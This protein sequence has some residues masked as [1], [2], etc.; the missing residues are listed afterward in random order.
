MAMRKRETIA[1]LMPKSR[2]LS[3]VSDDPRVRSAMCMCSLALMA[4][5]P[6]GPSIDPQEAARAKCRGNCLDATDKDHVFKRNIDCTC[7]PVACPGDSGFEKNMREVTPTLNLGCPQW[8]PQW[9]ADCNGG[10]CANCAVNKGRVHDSSEL[11]QPFVIH[12]FRP[13]VV[14]IAVRFEDEIKQLYAQQCVHNILLYAQRCAAHAATV[15]RLKIAGVATPPEPALVAAFASGPMTNGKTI[16]TIIHPRRW[17]GST[18]AAEIVKRT[19]SDGKTKVLVIDPHAAITR[20]VWGQLPEECTSVVFASSGDNWR[21]LDGTDPDIIVIE[22]LMAIPINPP[23][24]HIVR[25]ATTAAP[26]SP[27]AIKAGTK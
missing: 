7:V 22:G 6:A 12:P 9:L 1:M 26:A 23:N 19:T 17:G 8:M 5:A 2:A 10:M 25:I 18:L 13:A 27:A 16:C 4:A 15:A 3:I 21:F 11:R 24:S 20:I 14:P